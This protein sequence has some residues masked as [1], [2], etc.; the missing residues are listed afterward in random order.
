MVGESLDVFAKRVLLK[1]FFSIMCENPAPPP[2]PLCRLLW[3]NRL[4]VLN[5]VIMRGIFCSKI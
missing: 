1:T 4:S 3:P 2:C 5:K